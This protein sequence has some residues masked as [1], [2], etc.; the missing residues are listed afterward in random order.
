MNSGLTERVLAF[1]KKRRENLITGNINS[2]PSEFRRFSGE[3]IGV[4]QG[5]MYLM[6]AGTKV[7]KTQI[8]SFIFIFNTLLYSYY[9]PNKANVKIFYYPLEETQEAIMIRFMSFLLNH[10]SGGKV[11]ISPTD[12]KSSKNDNPLDEEI[13]ELL[14]SPEYRKILNHF[15]NNITFSSSQNATGVWKEMTKYAEESGTTYRK[16]QKVKNELGQE[17]EI[18]VFD[19]YKQH[20]EKEY[21]II[22]FDHVSLISTERGLS[23]KQS[24][25]KLSEYLVHLRNRYNFTPVVIQQQAFASESLDAQRDNKVRPTIA[26]L[27]DS[28]YISRDCDVCLGL[29]SPFRFEL[30]EYMGYDVRIFRDNIRFLEV[31]I[32]RGGSPGG[33]VPLFFD[34]CTN[35]YSELP[36]PNDMNGLNAIYEYIKYIRSP[37]KPAIINLTYAHIKDKPKSVLNNS[38]LSKIKNFFK[39][40]TN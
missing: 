2:I 32:N 37:R 13:L 35:F 20:D 10:L 22:F 34:G 15:E 12:L 24:I 21:R 4:E 6:T 27:S 19:Y 39:L 5:K 23:Q 8:G 14:D 29:F 36:Q 38:I 17:S 25:D 9:N 18:D 11:R 33:I 3:F 40:K 31:L 1:L 28:K 30:P 26:N 7:G 16:K